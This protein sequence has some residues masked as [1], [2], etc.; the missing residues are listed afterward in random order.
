VVSRLRTASG[1]KRI[2]HSGTLDPFA[3]GLLIVGLGRASTKLLGQYLHAPKEYYGRIVLGTVTDTYDPTGRIIEQNSFIIP[4][5]IQIQESLERFKGEI[6]QIP[7]LFS[8]LKMQ[9]KRLY[10]AARQGEKIIP[11]PRRVNIFELELCGLNE[12]GFNLRVVCSGGTYIRSL[13]YDLG[14]DLG[15]GGHLAQL[16][17][18]RIGNFT[19]EQTVDLEA[20]IT[21][22]KTERTGG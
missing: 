2:G 13:A 17:R 4:S 3:E 11:P 19:I 7:P 22:L 16:K 15:M 20:L 21:Q 1:V 12:D 10:K 6:Q 14:R 18:T 5:E 9:G 8:A